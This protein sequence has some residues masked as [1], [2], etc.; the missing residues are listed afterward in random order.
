[1]QFSYYLLIMAG[2]AGHLA[3]WID[4][5]NRL[6][7]NAL[8]CLVIRVLSKLIYITVLVIPPGLYWAVQTAAL[9]AWIPAGYI[10]L[11]WL[12]FAL[13]AA[14]WVQRRWFTRP[15]PHLISNHTKQVNVVQRLGRRPVSPRWTRG[16]IL[17]RVPRNDIFDLSVHEKRIRL[18]RLAA[19]L[20]G[21]SIVHLSD[22]HF[23]GDLQVDFFHELVDQA[24]L[25]NGDLVCIT[26]DIIDHPRCLPWIGETL[27]R[28]QSREGCFCV[29]GNHDKR[30][31]D[32]RG[33]RDALDAAG[34]ESLGG[35]SIFRTVRGH[36]IM[37]A[38]N[39]L[40]W[41]GPAPELT[42]NTGEQEN[43][44]LRLL[45][46]HSPD[47]VFWARRNRFD[48]MLAGHTHGGQLRLPLIGPWICPSHYGVR[49]AAGVY[50]LPPT[51][52][53]VSRGIS[54]LRPLR[55]NCPPE[56]TR[57]VLK[58]AD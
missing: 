30:L 25:L 40:P 37:L 42:A 57:L 32:Q 33:L 44:S 53:H 2:L 24:N 5:N 14:R 8:P 55:W 21:L 27:S 49:F 15:S 23:T 12:M 52:M 3:F 11:C 22:L 13:I 10:G 50:D 54:A 43:C 4:V 35:L 26:G 47:Q 16:T 17:T 19:A 20:D 38:G 6:H 39:E 41:Y 48:L 56:L 1:M 36:K 45:L 28:L 9:P 18:P 34:L 31:R 58:S 7:A 46:A 29:L 51:L